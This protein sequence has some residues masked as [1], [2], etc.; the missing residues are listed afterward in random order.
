MSL[1][2]KLISIVIPAYN[3][4]DCVEELSRRLVTLF[5][6]EEKFYNFE[7]IIV[8]NGSIDRTWQKLRDIHSRDSRFKIVKL[9]RNFRMDGGITAGID[10]VKG[11]ACV[12]M[13]ADLQDPPEFISTFLREW[14]KGW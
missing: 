14:E 3:E 10:F 2:K 12:L 13:T 1:Q 9:S 7:V 6:V 5:K 4:E 11:D 8:E